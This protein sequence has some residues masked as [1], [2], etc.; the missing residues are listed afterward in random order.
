MK[1]RNIIAWYSSMWDTRVYLTIGK[2]GMWLPRKSRDRIRTLHAW[3]FMC[4]WVYNMLIV[5]NCMVC[6]LR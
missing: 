6:V 1:Y 3:C 5:V 4:D 2:L